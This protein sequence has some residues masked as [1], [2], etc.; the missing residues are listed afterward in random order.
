MV[1]NLNELKQYDT[2]SLNIGNG[3]II[4]LKMSNDTQ[5]VDISL[6]KSNETL[7]SSKNDAKTE[8]NN[9][10]QIGTKD[11]LR[12]KE[13]PNFLKNKDKINEIIHHSL[14]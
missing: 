8:D 3:L 5:S 10:K 6:N 1:I 13:Y 12:N 9:I 7:C 4:D 14:H 11:L 2:I